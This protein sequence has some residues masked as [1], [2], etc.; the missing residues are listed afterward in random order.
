M[1]DSTTT[2]PSSSQEEH[3]KHICAARLVLISPPLVAV[4]LL[5]ARTAAT[6]LR[7]P[8]HMPPNCAA[9]SSAA[10]F[11]QRQRLKRR[12][13]A[14]WAAPL[15]LLVRTRTLNV[16]GCRILY[17]RAGTRAR[18]RDAYAG[19]GTGA[20]ARIKRVLS[21]RGRPSATTAWAL[22]C[23]RMARAR[24]P[25]LHSY[26]TRSACTINHAQARHRGVANNICCC[27]CGQSLR[28]R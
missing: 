1:V 20:S 26:Q 8:P 18:T 13:L 4:A 14:A 2:F 28:T 12:H 22:L 6:H 19:G 9:C 5:A 25:L 10:T 16:R 23:W 7:A 27:A 24:L 11:R 17:R 15:A 21:L 3:G